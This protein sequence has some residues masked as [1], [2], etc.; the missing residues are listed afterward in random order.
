[1]YCNNCGA[2]QPEQAVFCSECGTR[3]R[4]AGNEADTASSETP[5]AQPAAELPTAP[6]S[7][8]P[9]ALNKKKSRSGRRSAVRHFMW[10]V[11]VVLLGIGIGG[12]Y[13]LYERESGINEQV[14][15]LHGEAGKLALAGK[16]AEALARLDQAEALRPDYEALDTDREL[17]GTAQRVHGKLDKVSSQLKQN[18]LEAAEKS[19]GV[20]EASLNKRAEPLFERE[21]KAAAENRDRLSVLAVK[22]ELD[23]LDTVDAL[24]YKLREVEKLK[25]E[26]AEEVN[27]LIVSRIVSISTK[28]AEELLQDKSFDQAFEEVNQGL[29]Y[30]SEDES[31]LAL[32]DRIE[33][34]QTAFEAAEQARIE[35]AAQ[36]A[37]ADDLR[38]RTAAVEV[39]NLNVAVSEYGDITTT[40]TVTNT[41]TRSIYGIEIEYSAY[42]ASGSYLFSSTT[43]ASPYSLA[44]GTVGSFTA[45]DYGWYDYVE[46]RVDNVYWYLD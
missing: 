27:G 44:P 40:G 28:N 6:L 39:D 42:D 10:M 17:V 41:G 23:K 35:R 5:F 11:P 38:N 20:L 8:E 16:Y 33:S 24:V 32:Q 12:V 9:N 46:I 26:E 2:Q 21:K 14:S 1:M 4:L 30:A 13:G 15:T 36:Q 37:Q 3:L 18:Q 22:Q 7:E 19:L 25:T 31:L 43:F 34:E 45:Y 29:L